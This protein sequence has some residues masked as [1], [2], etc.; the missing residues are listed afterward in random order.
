MSDDDDEKKVGYCK[1]PVATR[2]QKGRSGNPKGRPRGS[3]N[4]AS[5]ISEVANMPVQVKIGTRNRKVSTRQAVLMQLRNGAL[6]GHVKSAEVL[7]KQ[8]NIIDSGHA[9]GTKANYDGDAALI[10]SFLNDY[11]AKQQ[12]KV[13]DDDPEAPA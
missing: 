11:L 6:K 9:N 2:F 10:E 13:L 12:E 1:P 5:I 8:F 7:L 3:R 4:A